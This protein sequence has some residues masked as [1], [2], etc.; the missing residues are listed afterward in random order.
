MPLIII[1]TFCLD[2]NKKKIA[3]VTFRQSETP[4]YIMLDI[5]IDFAKKKVITIKKRLFYLVQLSATK[6]LGK[7]NQKIL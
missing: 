3:R 5:Y 4:F 1:I 2:T 6:N 7:I